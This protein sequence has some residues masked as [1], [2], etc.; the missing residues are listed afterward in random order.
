MRIVDIPEDVDKWQKSVMDKL[1]RYHEPNARGIMAM[2][3][4][5]LLDVFDASELEAIVTL[6]AGGA[7]ALDRPRLPDQEF[8]I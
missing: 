5:D 6:A 4:A 7:V 1:R 3:N 8:N 2:M